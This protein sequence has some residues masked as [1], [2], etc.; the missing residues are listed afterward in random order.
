[1]R[2]LPLALL[3]VVLSSFAPASAQKWVE[4]KPQGAGFRLEFPQAPNIVR[5]DVKDRFRRAPNRA[6]HLRQAG[7]ARFPHFMTAFPNAQPALPAA[8]LRR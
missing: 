1:M 7:S 4:Y 3:L 5:Y 2:C 8:I 6:R